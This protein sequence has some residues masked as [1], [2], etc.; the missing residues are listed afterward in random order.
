[1]FQ[2]MVEIEDDPDIYSFVYENEFYKAFE[3]I[4]GKRSIHSTEAIKF[5]RKF[6]KF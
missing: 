2:K 5:Y 6:L 1:M 4:S 3:V